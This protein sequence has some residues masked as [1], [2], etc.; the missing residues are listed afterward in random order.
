MATPGRANDECP[1]I[2]A[3]PY[4]EFLNG[5]DMRRW[6]RLDGLSKTP[7]L[8]P[9]FLP[10]ATCLLPLARFF[11]ERNVSDAAHKRRP[12]LALRGEQSTAGGRKT[13][14]ERFPA[15]PG[16]SLRGPAVPFRSLWDRLG[17][18]RSAQDRGAAGLQGNG[19]KRSTD[20]TDYTDEK[21]QA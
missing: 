9:L 16:R 3:N 13:R 1:M 2:T 10:S 14:S 8:P 18:P 15:V 12:G 6:P 11:A 21:R 5:R 19:K 20:C 7:G 4:S 17:P